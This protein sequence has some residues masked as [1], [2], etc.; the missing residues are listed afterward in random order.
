MN[1]KYLLKNFFFFCVCV[2]ILGWGAQWLLSGLIDFSEWE[3]SRN[4]A[5]FLSSVSDSKNQ[6]P[7]RDWQVED[8][9]IDSEAA[10]SVES[11]LLG[12][13]KILFKK[14]GQK[15][16]AIASLTKLMTAIVSLESYELFE[17]ITINK[18]AA[19]QEGEQGLLTTGEALSIKNLLYIM[20]IESSNHAAY[21]LAELTGV[22]NFVDLMNYQAANIGLKDTYF[23]DPI[24]LSSENYST[25]E[26]LAKLAKYILKNYPLI[27]DISK[28][29][30][31]NLYKKDGSFYKKLVNTNKLLG[32]IPEIAGGK[33]GFTTD[34]KGSLLL[35]I[36][37]S[38]DGN[39]LIYVVLGADDRFLEM[40][41]IIDWVNAAYKW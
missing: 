17:E 24:G 6:P 11:D 10:I 20:L 18:T 21:A 9:E 22:K 30:E 41:K 39:Y 34:A 35:I 14:N 5:L 38:K 16:L 3:I 8:L 2:F 32:E 15:R 4:K 13:D 23:A 1:Y 19:L 29:K 31:F 36:K 25:V 40:K 12:S 26:D 27:A 28:T 7:Y 33:T 37:N